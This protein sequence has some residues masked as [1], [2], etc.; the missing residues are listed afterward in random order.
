MLPDD[1]RCVVSVVWSLVAYLM[2]DVNCRLLLAVCCLCSSVGVG[3]CLLICC[4]LLV[5]CVIRFVC[6]AAVVVVCW[7]VC[8]V[9]VVVRC[10]KALLLFVGV[11]WC[12]V[13]V[14]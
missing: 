13:S 10:C 4:V 3:S 1:V 11:V 9:S 14:A 12:C 6:C 2:F 7:F 5:V 8:L